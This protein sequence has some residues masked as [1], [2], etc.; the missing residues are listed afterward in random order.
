MSIHHAP[1]SK[2]FKTFYCKGSYAHE[3][4]VGPVVIQWFYQPWYHDDPAKQ[5]LR[6]RLFG[7]HLHVWCDAYWQRTSKRQRYLRSAPWG[8]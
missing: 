5:R 6:G 8:V 2:W 4:Q 3:L 1:W 7:H